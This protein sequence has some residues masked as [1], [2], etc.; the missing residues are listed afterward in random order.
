MPRP[1][2]TASKQKQEKQMEHSV[3]AQRG[4]RMNSLQYI[5][6]GFPNSLFFKKY[7]FFKNVSNIQNMFY[8]FVISV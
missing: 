4:L 2:C 7:C 1:S 8:S 3:F 5:F 6:R